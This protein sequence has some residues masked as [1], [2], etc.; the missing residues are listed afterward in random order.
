MEHVRYAYIYGLSGDQIMYVAQASECLYI[1]KGREL[2][3]TA[4]ILPGGHLNELDRKLLVGFKKSEVLEL[5]RY[6]QIDDEQFITVTNEFEVKHSFFDDLRR[7]LNNLSDGAIA[8]IM[9]TAEHFSA[10][11]DIDVNCVA[12]SQ[13][14]LMKLDEECQFPALQLVLFSRSLAPVIIPGPFGTG[15]TRVLAVAAY[16]FV[17][18]AKQNNSVCRV[19]VCSHHQVSADTFIESYFGAMWKVGLVR[20]TRKNYYT[21][22]LA[23]EH[24]YVPIDTFKRQVKAGQY[25]NSKQLV[26]VTTFLTALN[27]GNLF[28]DD[29]FTHI[30]LDE[31]AQVREP[32]AVAPLC[33][34]NRNTKI[35]IAGDS[36]QVYHSVYMYTRVHVLI[37][38]ACMYIYTL[39]T[40]SLL[41]CRLA[42]PY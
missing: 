16:N 4:D 18:T 1:L 5:E 35:V 10:G 36:K 29:F 40:S 25:I 12:Y 26:I 37:L 8:R 3:A 38:C 13:H 2:V 30:L 17:E 6:F 32:E 9:P 21:S 7:S 42:Q 27:I 20:L 24:L 11:L 31:G 33:M 34:A 39:I 23:Y 15:K 14:S 19:L 41:P 28:G 22:G